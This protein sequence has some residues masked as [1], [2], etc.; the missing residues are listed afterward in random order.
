MCRTI[1]FPR[2]Y[3]YIL[4]Y[5]SYTTLNA[6]EAWLCYWSMVDMCGPVH[7]Q[8]TCTA[9]YN[10]SREEKGT[11]YVCSNNH[12]MMSACKEQSRHGKTREGRNP[13]V[14][15]IK[16]RLVDM[17]IHMYWVCAVLQKSWLFHRSQNLMNV[18]TKYDTVR[19]TFDELTSP[20]AG[21]FE[22]NR[23]LL[24]LYIYRKL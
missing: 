22:S 7:K 3:R 13:T 11:L 21:A 14:E 8:W 19:F 15:V 24:C 1:L 9:S 18:K 6:H 16:S 12:R 5:I 2:Y 20:E 17:L 10:P 23:T 4:Y